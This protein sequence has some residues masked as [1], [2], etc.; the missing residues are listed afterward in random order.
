VSALPESWRPRNLAELEERPLVRPTL[1]GVGFVYPG[2]RHVFSGER[3]SA[4]TLAAYAVA[5]EVL[6]AG[7]RVVVIDFEMG[8]WDARDRLR[9]LSATAEELA[10]L[11]YIQP[12]ERATPAVVEALIAL[13]PSLVIIDAAAGAY[14]LQGL[15]DNKRGEVERF[16]SLYVQPFWRREIATIVID[17]VVKDP[18]KRR[19]YAIGSERKGGAADVHL[20]F[21]A[22]TKL[23]RG[24]RGVYKLTTFKDRPTWLRRPTAGEL[25]VESGEGGALRVQFQ[26]AAAEGP[27]PEDGFRPT[28]LMERVSRYLEAQ[29]EPVPRSAVEKYVRGSAEYLRLAIDCLVREGYTSEQ[30]GPRNAR[31]LLS[32]QAF[33]SDDLVPTSS[34]GRT[35]D[36]VPTSS[37]AEP[38][39]QAET[40]P[41]PDLVATSSEAENVTSSKTAS[42]PTGGGRPSENL[43][44]PSP[45]PT[46]RTSRTA[47]SGSNPRSESDQRVPRLA[48]SI[49]E[50]AQALG[51]SDDFLREHILDELRVVHRGRRR[52]VPVRELERW[53]EREAARPLQGHER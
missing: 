18:E 47:S 11:F 31:L 37:L 32:V 13:E 39:N 52:L 33:R 8:E 30:H 17:H 21:E 16:A 19:G 10:R 4:K 40:R 45:S 42:S 14:E 24:G 26:A 49:S 20:G 29:S 9:E 38:H 48:L 5:V 15:D 34:P 7:G 51:V 25:H 3:E 6:R 1:G 50:A 22:I 27:G 44:P 35:D 2:K 23:S 43:R 36:L 41:R 28:V 12:E 53:L 46:S